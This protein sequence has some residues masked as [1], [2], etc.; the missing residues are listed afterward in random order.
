MGCW[1]NACHH[2]I[3]WKIWDGK[4]TLVG[5]FDKFAVWKFYCQ[6]IFCY[7]F[8]GGIVLY[9]QIVTQCTRIANQIN[10]VKRCWWFYSIKQAHRRVY[11]CHR[12][13]ST[14]IVDGTYAIPIDIIKR[15]I[16]MWKFSPLTISDFL[17]S[18]ALFKKHFL[19][20]YCGNLNSNYFTVALLI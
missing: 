4:V 16:R 20:R 11:R 6:R 17:N 19:W 7:P 15:Y 18:V 8:F 1:K 3:F 12:I 13:C 5:V 9:R 2:G 10:I 14:I